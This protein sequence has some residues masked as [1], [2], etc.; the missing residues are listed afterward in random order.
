MN[1]TG[2]SLFKETAIRDGL[3]VIGFPSEDLLPNDQPRHQE[4][5]T[6]YA[7]SVLRQEANAILGQIG[8]LDN[9]FV[10]AIDLVLNCSGKIVVTGMGK[11]GLIGRKIAATFASTG[12][13]AFFIHPSEAVHGDLGMISRKDLLLILSNSG[14]TEEIVRLL[15][16]LRR[17][18][19]AVISLTASPWSSLGRYST[20]VLSFGSLTE[21]DSFNLAPTTSTTVMLAL[22]DAL[23]LSVSR[24]QGFGDEDFA[25][26]HP[27][28]ALGKRLCCVEDYMR[29]IDQCRICGQEMS[30]REIFAESRLPGRRSGAI[31]LVDKIGKLSGI[32]TDSDLARIFERK[33]FAKLEEPVCNI[34]TCSPYIAKIGDKMQKAVDLMAEK[35]IS[36]L[37]VL[38][39]NDIPAGMLD[40]TDLVSF[41]PQSTAENSEH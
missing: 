5:I 38:D 35:K 28:G 14:E 37:P 26:F 9:N 22:G 11:A 16:A 25:R 13:P 15:P 6:E 1:G 40:I 34:M 29:P 7:K 20:T 18:G 8:R 10:K 19:N 4:I 32:F 36:E 12:K 23:A 31:I 17:M 33:D 3:R 39:E 2:M 41:L 30:V 21:A 24:L 27:G